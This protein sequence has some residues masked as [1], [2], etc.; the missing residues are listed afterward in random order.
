ML[1]RRSF[2]RWLWGGF[3]LSLS[4]F[5]ASG[6]LGDLIPTIR[7]RRSRS[8]AESFSGEELVYEIG[9]WLFKRVALGRLSFSAT[10]NRGRYLAILETETLGILG[11]V[12][13]Y[14]VDTYRSIM[15]ETEEG[16]RLRS[17]SFEEDVKIG[18]RNEK[19]VT[20]F[21]YERRKWTTLKWRKN[22]SIQRIE[23]DIPP[24]RFY[25]DFLT[26]AYNFRYG[27]YGPVERG[28]VYTVP[29]FPRKGSTSYE[30]RVASREEEEKRRRSEKVR[31]QKEFF[32]KLKMDAEITHSREGRIEGWL[33]KDFLPVEGT[34][35]DVLLFGDVRGTLIGNNKHSSES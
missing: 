11:W 30:V 3:L 32:L 15:E 9:F 10:E 22:G 4:P 24:G 26:A 13:R 1:T 7:Q 31:D 19:R 27:V 17:L 23:E 18:N 12:S 33:S 25:D 20:Q 6:A 35:K 2:L 29:T 21:D 34:L 8:I 28:K 14:R 16:T 5:S